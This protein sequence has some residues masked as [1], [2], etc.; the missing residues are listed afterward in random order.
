MK[1]PT[2]TNAPDALVSHTVARGDMFHHYNDHGH[3]SFN[4]NTVLLS[5]IL[6][7][8]LILYLSMIEKGQIQTLL[9]LS[10]IC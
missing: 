8:A 5:W 9:F 2:Q 4:T 1:I 6:T 7:L 10:N 3:C